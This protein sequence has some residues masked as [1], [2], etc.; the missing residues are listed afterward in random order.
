LDILYEEC[1]VN[2]K[3]TRDEKLYKIMNIGFYISLIVS[4]ISFL[5]ALMNMPLGATEGLTGDALTAYEYAKALFALSLFIFFPFSSLAIVLFLF[6]RRVN[7]SYDYTFVSGELR[8]VKVFNVN[9]RK[10]VTKIQ[11]EDILQL[12]DLENETYARLS[13][14]TMNKQVI[15]TPNDEPMKG[16]FFMY[17]HVT[18]P[19]GNKL[20]VLECRE[21]LLVNILKFV[22]RGTLET[23]YVMQEKKQK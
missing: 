21:E 16:K 6:K 8:I 2:Q 9:R 3:A 7:I 10:L 12:G 15:C 23:D 11:P 17:A 20:Y 22:K 14:N 19:A 18:E 5:S 13:A 4:I 1:A